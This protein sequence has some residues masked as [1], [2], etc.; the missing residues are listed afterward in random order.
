MAAAVAAA[1]SATIQD[2]SVPAGVIIDGV[3][4]YRVSVSNSDS[5]WSVQKR[6]AGG[7]WFHFDDVVCVAVF[8]FFFSLSQIC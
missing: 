3:A 6:F 7:P 2:A 4:F 1:S 5:Q 8:F